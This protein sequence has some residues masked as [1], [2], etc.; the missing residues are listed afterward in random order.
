MQRATIVTASSQDGL[1]VVQVLSP[2]RQGRQRKQLAWQYLEMCGWPACPG[3]HSYAVSSSHYSSPWWRLMMAYCIESFLFKN[4]IK[5][6]KPQLPW[7][8][9]LSQNTVPRRQ[10]LWNSGEHDIIYCREG[11]H[12][13]SDLGVVQ[14]HD[15]GLV[16][17]TRSRY[18]VRRWCSFVYGCFGS[19]AHRLF[20]R[21]SCRCRRLESYNDDTGYEIYRYIS[22]PVSSSHPRLKK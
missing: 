20:V 1:A 13:S 18:D 3:T 8:D 14:D 16:D 9:W 12:Y 10:V 15:A 17:G 4:I 19:F 5:P 22:Y 2:A 11:M 21:C 6:N 7:L